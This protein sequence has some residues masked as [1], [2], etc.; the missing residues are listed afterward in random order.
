MGDKEAKEGGHKADADK[1]ETTPLNNVPGSK[2]KAGKKKSRS[3]MR[4]ILNHT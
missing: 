1:T 3:K 2:E 4:T